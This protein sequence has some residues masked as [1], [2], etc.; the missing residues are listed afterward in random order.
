MIS[1]IPHFKKEYDII[2]P[3]NNDLS[4]LNSYTQRI[5]TNKPQYSDGS[6]LLL[7][8]NNLPYY[9][10]KFTGLFPTSIS[11]FIMNSSDGPDNILTADASFRY[12]YYDVKKLF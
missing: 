12:S 7:S 1:R 8:S 5:S 6:L 2:A 10:F 11:S 3:I 4:N 9:E